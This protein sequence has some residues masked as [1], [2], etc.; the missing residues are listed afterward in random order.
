MLYTSHF[1]LLLPYRSL[2]MNEF[3][4]LIEEWETDIQVITMHLH[5]LVSQA[6]QALSERRRLQGELSRAR[7]AQVLLY[8]L[9]QV[10]TGA[11][12]LAA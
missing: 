9:S 5:Q 12:G 6:P 7:Q 3:T 11:L 2:L 1:Y 4:L 10:H 8:S